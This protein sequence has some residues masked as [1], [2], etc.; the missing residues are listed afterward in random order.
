MTGN[1]LIMY[2]GEGV[3][4]EMVC[5]P[6]WKFWMGNDPNHHTDYTCAIDEVPLQ[7]VYLDTYYI[8]LYEVA[9]AHCAQYVVTCATPRRRL[10]YINSFNLIRE[11]N[12]YANV[13][14]N[15]MVFCTDDDDGGQS[16]AGIDLDDDPLQAG[17]GAGA[18]AG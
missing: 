5:I 1:E 18:S 12:S 9:N 11:N 7:T 3:E 6:A 17:H 4:M 8:D 13:M 16:F 10:R 15:L 14:L 2:L